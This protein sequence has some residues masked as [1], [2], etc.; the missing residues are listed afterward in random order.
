MN[1][2]SWI[3]VGLFGG[4]AAVL[5]GWV[6]LG[7]GA[8]DSA[9]R[10]VPPPSD[11]AA[12]ATLKAFDADKPKLRPNVTLPT[13]RMAPDKIRME[14]DREGIALRAQMLD[15]PQL[16]RGFKKYDPVEATPAGLATLVEERKDDLDSCF[17]AAKLHTPELDGDLTLSL[18]LAGKGAGLTVESVRTDVPDA[19]D[20]TMLEGCLATVFR[21][22]TFEGEPGTLT[23]AVVLSAGD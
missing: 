3:L 21:E 1:R 8:A 23:Q 14:I 19:V 13:T 9:E 6:L 4:I 10:A 17:R 7:T 12:R 2:G 16:R 5:A 20:A 11:E 15:R 22:M 18:E